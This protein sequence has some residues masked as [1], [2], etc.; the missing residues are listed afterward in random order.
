MHLCEMCLFLRRELDLDCLGY[1]LGHF[2]LEG[3]NIAE[4]PFVTFD[5][6]V[7]L[8]RCVNE[9]GRDAHAVVCAEHR[10]FHDRVHFQFPR[11]L[12]QRFVNPLVP[13]H[14]CACNDSQLP[15]FGQCSN[16]RLSE[17]FSEILL[18]G[19]TRQVLQGQD[20]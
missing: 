19:V 12:A 18:L 7:R 8:S 3:Q 20:G 11:N 5:P 10:A 13:H 14:G 17:S 2:R 4:V 16:Q 15:N 6:E 1:G 9:L